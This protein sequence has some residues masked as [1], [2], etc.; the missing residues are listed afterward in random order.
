L[1][2]RHGVRREQ[3]L[4]R[5]SL[6]FGFVPQQKGFLGVACANVINLWLA[7]ATGAFYKAERTALCS[8]D[9]G[10]L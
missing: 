7:Q 6:G 3:N 4:C 8:A 10:L 9:I 2:L 1:I 5:C